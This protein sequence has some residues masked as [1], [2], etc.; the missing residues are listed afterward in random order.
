MKYNV[1]GVIC[2]LEK[3]ASAIRAALTD[4]TEEQHGGLRF[5]VGRYGEKTVVLSVC[6]V[7]KVFA[8]LCAQ[9]MLLCY[10]PRCLINSGVAG[11]LSEELEILDVA[12]SQNLVQHDMDTSP[13]GDPVG[14]ISGLN[15]VY[16]PADE[17]LIRA[18]QEAAARLGIRTK[19]GTVA[20]GDQFIAK[21]EQKERI[22]SLFS[23]IAC[24][25][26]GAAAAQVAA[27]QQVPFVA[28][29]AISD[30]YTGQNEMDYP[31]FAVAAAER[32]AALLLEMLK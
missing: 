12:V 1:I 30:S 23:A 18:A 26:E 2:A 3:E 11:S 7:G 4:A 6:G 16:L 9:T 20:S 24:E 31:R 21:S 28:L 5:T 25:M 14:L 27:L 22:R 10:Q 15:L 19:T 29:R 8:A 17:E 32:G 13:L